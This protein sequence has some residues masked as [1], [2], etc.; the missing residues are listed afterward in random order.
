MSVYIL[1]SLSRH[2]TRKEPNSLFPVFF[3]S[4]QILHDQ[5]GK[6][7][8]ALSLNKESFIYLSMHVLASVQRFGL[9][10]RAGEDGLD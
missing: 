9:I 2:S 10:G 3:S 6:H 8:E 7:Y 4:F 1:G 5:D